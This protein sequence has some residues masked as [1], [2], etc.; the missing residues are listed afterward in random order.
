MKK[1]MA[2]SE[3]QEDTRGT[4]QDTTSS[5]ETWIAERKK[6]LKEQGA[7]AEGKAEWEHLVKDL[8][9]DAWR[10]VRCLLEEFPESDD[11]EESSRRQ[12]VVGRYLRRLPKISMWGNEYDAKWTYGRKLEALRED[13]AKHPDK[14]PDAEA[15]E[16]RH[17]RQAAAGHEAW[18]LLKEGR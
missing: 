11:R 15:I 7:K 12:T 18:K 1:K 3:D 13:R 9:D 4:A 14:Y 17:W 5:M 6:R 2:F 16:S 10:D 8:N